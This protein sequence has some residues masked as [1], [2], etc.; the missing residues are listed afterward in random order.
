M[1]S[2]M[3]VLF[4]SELL[5]FQMQVRGKW[6]QLL[7]IVLIIL[8][9]FSLKTAHVCYFTVSIGQDSGRGLAGPSPSGSLTR[10]QLRCLLGLRLLIFHLGRICFQVHMVVG[11]V[12]FFVSYWT[13]SQFLTGYE[14]VAALDSL[15]HGPLQRAACNMAALSSYASRET[16]NRESLIARWKLDLT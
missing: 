13:E 3:H 9:Q 12:Q 10:L 5:N 2:L 1:V 8:S 4:R 11:R 14:V 7:I 15:P 16:V 6:Y